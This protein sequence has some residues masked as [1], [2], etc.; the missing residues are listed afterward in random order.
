MQP[1]TSVGTKQI[2]LRNQRNIAYLELKIVDNACINHQKRAM[3][4]TPALEMKFGQIDFI[5]AFFLTALY[6]NISWR[7]VQKIK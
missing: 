3:L 2:K 1:S 5:P 6:P 7:R 4:N